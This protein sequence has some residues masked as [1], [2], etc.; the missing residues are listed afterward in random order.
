VQKPVVLEMVLAFRGLGETAR[1]EDRGRSGSELMM[2]LFF[3]AMDTPIA[4]MALC[5]VISS[6]G[7]SSCCPATALPLNSNRSAVVLRGSYLK[8]FQVELGRT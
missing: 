4:C 1:S 3:D 6:S 7:F 8:A 2:T 5:L